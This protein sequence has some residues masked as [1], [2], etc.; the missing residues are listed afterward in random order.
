MSEAINPIK[1]GVVLFAWRGVLIF[2]LCNIVDFW[3][4]VLAW[5]EEG[6]SVYKYNWMNQEIEDDQFGNDIFVSD[7][8][9]H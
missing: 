8:K 1:G 9:L 7:F 5:Y 4:V 6:R 3:S 2:V